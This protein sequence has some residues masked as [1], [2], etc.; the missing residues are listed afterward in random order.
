MIAL[1][2]TCVGLASNLVAESCMH[3]FLVTCLS[4]TETI[5]NT[6]AAITTG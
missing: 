2:N 4:I 1:C 3:E 5:I 6:L